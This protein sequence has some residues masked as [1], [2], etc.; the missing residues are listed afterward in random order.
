MNTLVVL[1]DGAADDKIPEFGNKTPL[2]YLHKDFIDGIASHGDF[3]L[4]DGQ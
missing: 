2:E 4:T 1:L 3:G